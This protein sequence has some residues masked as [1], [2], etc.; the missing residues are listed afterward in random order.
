MGKQV[1]STYGTEVYCTVAAFFVIAIRFIVNSV[2]QWN[3]KSSK[4][5]LLST[6]TPTILRSEEDEF[7]ASP[8]PGVPDGPVAVAHLSS[9]HPAQEPRQA[10]VEGLPGTLL[11]GTAPQV[12]DDQS[13][14]DQKGTLQSSD[15]G[16]T[17]GGE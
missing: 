17:G 12:E 14:A 15:W 3:W 16:K 9:R 8:A 6:L 2:E 10:L 7:A 4:K 1:L 5:K 11:V 13:E